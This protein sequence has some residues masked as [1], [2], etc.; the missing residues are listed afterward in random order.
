MEQRRPVRHA[1][2]VAASAV[3]LA[4]VVLVAVVV[5]V[6]PK[7]AGAVPLTVLSGSMEP[8]LPVGSIAVV[9]PVE[10][11][12]VRVGDVV[13]YQPFPLNPELVTHRVVAISTDS[14]GS[15]VFTLR[16]DANGSDDD[17]VRAKQIRARVWYDVPYLGWVNSALNGD[18]RGWFVWTAAGACFA[19]ATYNIARGLRERGRDPEPVRP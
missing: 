17:P 11:D 13:S 5:I 3:L 1:I 8:T 9:K 10:P 6:V 7:A 18:Q 19:Y 15:R 12:Q 16:G 2:G 4:A 14:D